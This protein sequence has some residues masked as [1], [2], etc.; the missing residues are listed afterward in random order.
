MEYEVEQILK[1][2]NQIFSLL[3][4]YPKD[5]KLERILNVVIIQYKENIWK[6][7]YENYKQSFS[8]LIPFLIFEN[9]DHFDSF[10]FQSFE[11]TKGIKKNI[12]EIIKY[13]YFLSQVC[14]DCIELYQKH[15]YDQL[16]DLFDTVHALP[17]S[18]CNIKWSEKKYWKTYFNTYNNKWGKNI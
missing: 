3:R 5:K 9:K 15:N 1:L 16:S 4:I 12:K 17:D 7:K 14:A 13:Q 11:D 8:E 18:L 6:W 2:T 10:C